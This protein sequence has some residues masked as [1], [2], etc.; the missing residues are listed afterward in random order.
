MAF[1]ATL[2]LDE[3]VMLFV[4]LLMFFLL[5]IETPLEASLIALR[6]DLIDDVPL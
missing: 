6:S 2:V 1:L 3:A 5:A 4:L